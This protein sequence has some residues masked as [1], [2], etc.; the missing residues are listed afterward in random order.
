MAAAKLLE[1]RKPADA[2][3]WV[4]RGRAMEREKRSPSAACYDL[5]NLHRELLTKLGRGEEALEA[6]WVDFRK[7]P[8]KYSYDDLMK[9]VPKAERKEWHEKAMSAA[10]GAELC[11]AIELFVETKEVDRLAELVHG[12]ADTSLE[13]VSHYATEPAA[14]KLDKSHPGLAARLWR[15]QGLRLVGAKKSKYY[16]A[17]LSNFERARASYLRAGLAAEWE[18]TVRNVCAAHFRKSGFIGEFQKL[19]AGAKRGE[20]PSFLEAAK[21]RWS[22]RL[23]S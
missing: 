11:S 4:E 15:A 21:Q 5:D 14:K 7:H 9:F 18:E 3:A 6:A 20:R 16:D 13:G 1:S 12:A 8:S 23:R 2:L 19:A 22:E 17:A 10:K